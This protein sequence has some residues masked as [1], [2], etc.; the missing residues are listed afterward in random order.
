MAAMVRIQVELLSGEGASLEVTPDMTIGQ[1]KEEVK[2]F[3]PSSDEIIRRL[4]SVEIVLDGAKLNDE[5]MSVAESLP[6]HAK[7]QALSR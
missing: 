6:D 3:H 7:V 1:L 4:S 2:A 5:S